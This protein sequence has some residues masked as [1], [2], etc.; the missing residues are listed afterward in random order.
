[1]KVVKNYRDNKELRES[2]NKLAEAT[3]GLNFEGWYQTGYWGDNYNPYSIVIDGEVVSNVSVNKTNM[4]V[5]GEIKHFIQLGTVMT[6]ESYRNR[7]YIRMIMN[8]ILS[9]YSEIVDGMYLF[10]NDSVCEFYPKFG[11]VQSKE[12]YHTKKVNNVDESNMR[13][14]VMDNPEAW[15]Q[16]ER[17]MEQNAFRGNFDMVENNGLI[18][19]YVTQF[20]NEDVYYH[21][22]SDTFVVMEVEERSVFIHNIFSTTLNKMDDVLKL[23]GK[24]IDSVTLGF[25]PLNS[26]VYEVNELKE[27]DCTFFIRG[28]EMK[29]LEEKKFRIPSL[30]H[31]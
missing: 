26:E 13:K 27:D 7:G 19:F 20:M 14:C 29:I 31:A 1:M 22:E 30:A 3:F 10:A 25:T 6:S 9:D 11:F 8:E 23:L 17:V 21:E 28:E 12:Y 4:L 15:K 18:M 2:F 16:L 5:N 24:E